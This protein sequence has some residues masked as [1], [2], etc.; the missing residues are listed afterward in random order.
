[1][2]LA[3]AAAATRVAAGSARP[4]WSVAVEVGSGAPGSARRPRSRPFVVTVSMRSRGN[5]LESPLA[6]LSIA[7][8]GIAISPRARPACPAE[9]LRAGIAEAQERCSRSL[10]G[11]L[12][13]RATVG[14]KGASRRA[15]QVS[16]CELAGDVYAAGRSLAVQLYTGALYGRTCLRSM[17]AVAYASLRAVEIGGLRSSE[18][19]WVVPTEPGDFRHPLPGYDLSL[20]FLELNLPLG[21]GPDA[22]GRSKPL[23]SSLGCERRRRRSVR[24]VFVQEDGT[25]TTLRR[26]ARC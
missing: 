15:P 8:A 14:P 3:A 9:V 17:F 12:E 25:R 1:M 7:A 4:A 6:R 20:D 2:A 21:F 18:L 23:V 16:S 13:G 22:A 10:V 19:R 11:F 24:A 26:E 5:R